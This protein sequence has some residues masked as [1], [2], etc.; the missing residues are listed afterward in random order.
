MRNI[1]R[2]V[3]RISEPTSQSN[4]T[5]SN[6][7]NGSTQEN[8]KSGFRYR[9][10]STLQ[11]DPEQLE[12][13][14]SHQ[15]SPQS[16]LTQR[17]PSAIEACDTASSPDMTL[18]QTS[19]DAKRVTS[20]AVHG[21]V[22][23]HGAIDR[24]PKK[25]R[26]HRRQNIT[27]AFEAPESVPECLE[28]SQMINSNEIA[29][30]TDCIQKKR[31]LRT[32]TSLRSVQRKLYENCPGDGTIPTSH[33]TNQI[34]LG[35]R[36]VSKNCEKSSRHE[37]RASGGYINKRNFNSLQHDR[38]QAIGQVEASASETPSTVH[39]HD[40][41]V[42]LHGSQGN[43]ANI[44]ISI[45]H[46]NGL[47]KK[48]ETAERL[49]S[50]LE[51]SGN[52]WKAECD[53]LQKELN[54][55]M[56]NADCQQLPPMSV[57]T[58][59]TSASK[60]SS[61]FRSKSRSM[62]LTNRDILRKELIDLEIPMGLATHVYTFF[63]SAAKFA[64]LYVSEVCRSSWSSLKL[65]I[66]WEPN[67]SDQ[68]A[69]YVRD[70]RGRCYTKKKFVKATNL[71]EIQIRKIGVPLLHCT[72]SEEQ[73]EKQLY[74]VHAAFVPLCPFHE[75]L[76]GTLYSSTDL[77][78]KNFISNGLASLVFDDGNTQPTNDSSSTTI[79][80]IQK[81]VS[82]SKI[83]PKLF[84]SKCSEVLSSR[85]KCAKD[86][87]FEALGYN[88]I[89]A[90]KT[91]QKNEDV[92]DLREQ[93]SKEAYEKLHGLNK[94]GSRDTSKWRQSEYNNICAQHMKS[95]ISGLGPV[96]TD[97]LFKNEIAKN[98][99][100]KFVRFGCAPSAEISISALI[101][102]D[103]II[104]DAVDALMKSANVSEDVAETNEFDMIPLQTGIQR[105]RS[106]LNRGGTV[107][108]ESLKRLK[109]MLPIAAAN[110]LSECF[111][112][113]QQYCAPSRETIDLEFSASSGQTTEER[114][115][116]DD[117]E[118]TICFKMPDNGHYYI[119]L[120]VHAFSDHICEWIGK[121]HDCFILHSSS[122][123]TPFRKFENTT[124]FPVIFESDE[125]DDERT[126]E[127]LN[128]ASVEQTT[129]QNMLDFSDDDSFASHQ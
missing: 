45:N 112:I 108:Q 67:D 65:S 49:N 40:G 37:N 15:L 28:N 84:K 55:A 92:D 51:S 62:V 25:R 77:F 54:K 18:H 1:P 33:K 16:N 76:K 34:V 122:L 128:D 7:L 82:C 31:S 9:R 29:K 89:M 109:V 47:K 48:L 91:S 22:S 93:Q 17:V 98:A 80:T 116:N 5:I 19:F 120:T 75:S 102:F 95:T 114:M 105:G 103:A 64:H 123:D 10:L 100:K 41:L 50:F 113:M 36:A 61:Y 32:R 70:W 119:A 79:E 14:V 97:R 111:E 85:K 73:R 101:R 27:T 26:T 60:N 127:T 20:P 83:L 118:L 38:Q 86:Y 4:P 44:T 39:F 81:F 117:R 126:N 59:S 8:T 12:A 23:Q 56:I 129:G 110:L 30:Q 66:D 94:D 107:P 53:R 104:T 2:K 90:K 58:P 57:P 68:E 78:L 24:H 74:D 99:F 63:D 87:F 11:A 96:T 115:N 124:P 125:E 106:L 46:Y 88:C 71:T 72:Q 21:T 69:E 121:V 43:S 3:R 42:D 6:S 13:Q 35:Q 52:L